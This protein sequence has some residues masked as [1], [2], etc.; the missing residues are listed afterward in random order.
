MTKLPFTKKFPNKSE[1][2]SGENTQGA[3]EK[4]TDNNDHENANFDL[5]N[6]EQ[7]N[8]NS[9]ENNNNTGAESGAGSAAINEGDD[10]GGKKVKIKNFNEKLFF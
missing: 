1:Q 4:T 9:A 10:K 3:L 5:E 2:P 7:K 6:S 8:L